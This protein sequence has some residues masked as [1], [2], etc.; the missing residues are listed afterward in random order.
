MPLL[1]VQVQNLR[2][3]RHADLR[4]DSKLTLITGPNAAGKTSLLEA[5]FFLGRGRS[6]RTRQVEPVIRVGADGLTVIGHLAAD[7][8]PL[9]VGIRATRDGTEARIGGQP[10]ASLADLATAFPV[11]VIDPS[12]HKLVEEGPS[13]RRRA[14]DWGVFHVEQ[15]FAADWQRYQRALRQR[16]AA[17]RSQLPVAAIRAWDTELIASG[18]SLS[19]ARERYLAHLQPTV[20]RVARA[21][22]GIEVAISLTRGWPSEQTLE[23]ALVASWARDTRFRTTTVGPHRADMRL[24]V[25]GFVAR[26]RVS[27][28]QQK[29]LAA[30]VI[31]GQLEV[32]RASRSRAGTLLLDDPAAELDREHL[33]ALMEQINTLGAQLIATATAGSI[34]G[35]EN[36][37]ARFHVEQGAVAPML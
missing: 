9:V 1:A 17:L 13:G 23:E 31:I 20:E 6:F 14:M 11:Q 24:L 10:V 28:G 26:D 30:A 35:L 21:L 37:G 36:P 32:L 27:R 16:N 3:L 33:H 5:V 4:L 8:R 25:E 34:A 12:V 2:C 22:I 15:G 7:V 29:L 18:G 19:A